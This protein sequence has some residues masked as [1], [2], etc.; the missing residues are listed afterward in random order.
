MLPTINR[1]IL[2]GKN[3]IATVSRR[4]NYKVLKSEKSS[5]YGILMTKTIREEKLQILGASYH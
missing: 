5:C 4:N 1:A 3:A 2:S